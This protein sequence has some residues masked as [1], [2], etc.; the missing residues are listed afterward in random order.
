MWY[1][2]QEIHCTQCSH[3]YLCLLVQ[4]SRVCTS[5]III[6][7]RLLFITSYTIGMFQKGDP[8]YKTIALIVAVIKGNF[9]DS[10]FLLV[11]LGHQR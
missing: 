6:I 2:S 3:L 4:N 9:S 11:V 10:Q 5:V 1:T 8:A 7:N